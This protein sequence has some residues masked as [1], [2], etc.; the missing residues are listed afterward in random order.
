[1]KA[2]GY[3]APGSVDVL[4]EIDLPKP[5]PRLRDLLVEVRAI[6]VNPV[7][8]KIRGGGGPGAPSGEAKVL[9]WDAAGVVAEVGTEVTHFA[10]G[11][12]VYY[13]GA[14]D[15]TGSNAEYQLVDERIVGQKPATI[16]FAE[17]AAL[18]LT[19]LTA[20]EMLFDRL[21]IRIGKPANIGS[22]LIIGGAG[23][24][25]SIAIQLA[26]RLTGLTI[27][28]TA[29]RPETKAWALKM[30]AHHVI[31]HRRPLA[32]QV[33]LIVPDGVKHVLALTRTEDHFDE[34]VDALGPQGA[35]VLIENPARPLD[36]VKLKPKS[37]SLHWEFMFTRARY[38]TADMDEQGRVLN[39]VAG[40]VDAGLIR[41]TMTSNLGLI[42]A[43]NLK[44]AHTI[45]ESG[46]AIGKVV[47]SGF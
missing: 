36:I 32:E 11:D 15:R 22:L 39:E 1:M 29:S 13:A 38:Q 7:D 25:G 17:A 4:Q 24:V 28:A 8:A 10:P 40:L 12:E 9:G 34:I 23:G 33:K 27:I 30:G 6:S 21:T 26:R 45:A 47:L 46:T 41:T 37:I 43:A 18:P 3:Y 44:R 20:W 14:L 16:G 2:I 31:D 5:K 19:T 35:L 42:N